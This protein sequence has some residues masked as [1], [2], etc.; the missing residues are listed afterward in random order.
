[1]IVDRILKTTKC[2]CLVG[3]A[4]GMILL[5]AQVR[6]LPVS[7]IVIDV[8]MYMGGEVQG[9]TNGY[10]FA[11]SVNL[12]ERDLVNLSL[13][14]QPRTHSTNWHGQ[15]TLGLVQLTNTNVLPLIVFDTKGST[16]IVTVGTV[17]IDPAHPTQSK[18]GGT[19]FMQVDL[20]NVGGI[21]NRVVNGQFF[22]AGTSHFE[23]NG[24]LK[25]FKGPGVGTFSAQFN[26]T[27]VTDVIVYKA[28]LSTQGNKIGILTNDTV[29]GL[30]KAS[31]STFVSP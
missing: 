25:R 20:L 10:A 18:N 7:N 26:S 6:A 4:G 17:T 29:F 3:V 9:F 13:G 2:W 5:C 8:S 23:T 21:S 24:C 30:D 11:A 14:L 1:M 22:F 12:T 15:V 19:V 27:N 31:P 16:N 28:R